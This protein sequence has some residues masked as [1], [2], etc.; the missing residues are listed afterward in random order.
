MYK[1][2]NAA[3]LDTVNSGTK[4]AWGSK[5]KSLYNTVTGQTALKVV[6]TII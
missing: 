4:G 6:A 1:A 5:K 2:E 3:L